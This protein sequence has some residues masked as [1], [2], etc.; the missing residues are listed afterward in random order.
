MYIPLKTNYTLTCTSA[1]QLLSY[2]INQPGVLQRHFHE[3]F[4]RI[5]KAGKNNGNF[6]QPCFDITIVFA[7]SYWLHCYCL[8]IFH[9]HNVIIGAV[10]AIDILITASYLSVEFGVLLFFVNLRILNYGISIEKR[11][12]TLVQRQVVVRNISLVLSCLEKCPICRVC[13]YWCR[14]RL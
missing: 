13:T 2:L 7:A 6:V 5:Y 11:S 3:I 12:N 8:D 4:L 14:V 9:I 1:S 10:S